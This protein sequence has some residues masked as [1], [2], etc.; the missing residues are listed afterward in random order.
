MDCAE[1]ILQ[2]VAD[3]LQETIDKNDTPVNV[4]TA[5]ARMPIVNQFALLFHDSFLMSIDDYALTRND[6]R[7][8]LK[9]IELM[10]FG[11]LVKISWSDVGSSLGINRSNMSRHM[12]NLRRARLIVDDAGGNTYLN[13]QII[14]KGKFLQQSGDKTLI[15]VLE[16]GAAAIEGTRMQPSILTKNLRAKKK[17]EYKDNKEKNL[18]HQ[19]NMLAMIDRDI[20]KEKK[21][22]NKK[23]K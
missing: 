19:M 10:K 1:T 8:V 4:F 11:N 3:D 18:K 12:A 7:V 22:G 15:E 5:P 21:V 16:L 17:A 23:K 13:P 14:A 6:I 9:I 2:K 20:E